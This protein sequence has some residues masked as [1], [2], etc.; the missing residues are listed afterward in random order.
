MKA[1]REVRRRGVAIMFEATGLY[2]PIDTR[3][4]LTAEDGV[5][6]SRAF[7]FHD[8]DAHGIYPGERYVYVD[9]QAFE[10]LTTDDEGGW[11]GTCKVTAFQ[12][13]VE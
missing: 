3:A 5:P 9:V 7:I 8:K 10:M 12:E 6:L 1:F 2:Y 13:V 4:Q 11:A